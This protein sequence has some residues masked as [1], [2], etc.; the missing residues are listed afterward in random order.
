MAPAPDRVFRAL[1]H[2]VRLCIAEALAGG[3]RPV[4]DLVELVGLGW[5]TVSRH[6]AVLREAGVV[7]DER[8][9]NRVHDTLAL[10]CVASFSQCIRAAQAGHE[11]LLSTR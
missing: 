9:G 4:G 2:P 6:L 7:G 8:R 11:V 3:P 1:G 5:S 10:P